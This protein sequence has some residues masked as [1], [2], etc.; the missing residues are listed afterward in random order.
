MRGGRYSPDGYLTMH[1]LARACETVGR[2]GLTVEEAG[3]NLRTNLAIIND[4][5]PTAAE[6][7]A[8][9]APC[10]WLTEC[11]VMRNGGDCTCEGRNA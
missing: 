5:K 2:A 1:E 4:A 9:L 8:A 7:A 6:A 11:P 10:A 3:R